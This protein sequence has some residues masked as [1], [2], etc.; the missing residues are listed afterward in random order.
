LPDLNIDINK[1][2]FMRKF[3]FKQC[4][5]VIVKFC[6]QKLVVYVKQSDLYTF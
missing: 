3:A 4:M 5:Q 1:E 2:K 6:E